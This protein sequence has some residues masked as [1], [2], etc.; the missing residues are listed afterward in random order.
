MLDERTIEAATEYSVFRFGRA[1]GLC[2]EFLSEASVLILVFGLL[3]LYAAGRL[4]VEV[5]LKIGAGSAVLFVMALSVRAVFY[6]ALKW[7]IKHS[8]AAI[9]GATM[10]R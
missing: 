4:T 3:D 9:E 7:M 2:T 8:S 5:G 10:R 6:Q 1:I